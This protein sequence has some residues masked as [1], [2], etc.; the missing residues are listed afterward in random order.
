M[1]RTVRRL[2]ASLLVAAATL[3]MLEG[4][5]SV[6]SQPLLLRRLSQLRGGGDSADLRPL[7]DEERRRAA[8]ENPGIWRAHV[9][10]RVGYVLR[11]YSDLA[12]HEGKI[13][14]DGLGLRQRPLPPPAREPF[15]IAVMGAS[16]PFGYGLSD[17]ETLAARLEAA[18]VAVRGPDSQPV[19]CRTVAMGRWNTLNAVS[20]LRDHMHDLRPDLVLFMPYRNDLSDTDAV[21]EAGHRRAAPDP[22]Q[23]DPWLSVRS[24]DAS[25]RE[26]LVLSLMGTGRL[27]PG[28]RLV[29][30]DALVGDLTAESSRRYDDNAARILRLRADLAARGARLAYLLYQEDPHAFHLLA[31]LQASAPDLEV[32]P[33]LSEV[34]VEFQLEGDPHPNAATVAVLAGWVARELIE[35][36]LVQGGPGPLPGAAPRAYEER[37][38]QRRSVAEI[39]ALS[40]QAHAEALAALQPAIE[41]GSGRGV[42]Q[43]YGGIGLGGTCGPRFAAVLA[44][45]GPALQV[46]LAALRERPDLYPLDIEVFAGGAALGRLTLQ[47]GATA[48]ARLPLPPGDGPLE[49]RLSAADWIVGTFTEFG[50]PET[51]AYRP[52]RL[53]CGED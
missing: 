6:A 12:I 44:R 34:P 15:R 23:P 46:E 5:L 19:I 52:V 47:A 14:S 18:L 35:R 36:G 2:G 37:R 17:D 41:F 45:R 43:I 20:F 10:P 8:A 51:A 29:G 31:R 25:L 7:S 48:R 22:A 30:P 1:R 27:E 39:E 13:R 33:L 26:R 3:L 38:A 24:D 42:R 49:V 11:T 21:D 50:A 16:I 9:D 53:A 28:G 40:R 4:A 32:I